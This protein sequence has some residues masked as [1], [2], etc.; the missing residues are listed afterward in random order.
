LRVDALSWLAE[1]VGKGAR[2]IYSCYH[3][4]RY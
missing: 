3:K 1:G 2:H 4:Y